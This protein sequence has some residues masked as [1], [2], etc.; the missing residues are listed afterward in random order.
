MEQKEIKSLK[1]NLPLLAIL[2]AVG[3]IF[4]VLSEYHSNEGTQ[5]TPGDFDEEEYTQRLE[6]RLSAIIEE[7]D[8]V[9]EVKVMITLESGTR[10]QFAREEKELAS[11]DGTSV[12]TFLMQEDAD[13][14]SSPILIETG[15]P[16]IKG[17]SVVCRGADNIL[18][19]EK[20]LGL[21]AGTLDLTK[22]KIYVTE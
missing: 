14:T 1:K 19:R 16:K 11:G 21:V 3:I 18:I 13:G 2:L 9:S 8:G 6:K 7:M 22:N 12:S 20:I 5:A 17:V 15:A 4:L 10:Y